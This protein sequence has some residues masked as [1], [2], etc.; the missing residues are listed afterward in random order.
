VYHYTDKDSLQKIKHSQV[1]LASKKIKHGRPTGDAA[2]GE[3]VY[4]T[5]LG[6][7][8]STDALLQNNY[9]H[10]DDNDRKYTHAYVRISTSNLRGTYF[11][12]G[13]THLERD[14]FVVTCKD[15]LNLDR[16]GAEFVYR[17]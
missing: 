14:V 5:S 6:P 1:L 2:I 10:V 3:G 8:T 17:R 9:G 15:G 7:E 13:R 4:F 11:R 16:I 12:S